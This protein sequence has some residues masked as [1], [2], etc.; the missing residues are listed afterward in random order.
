MCIEN[1][2]RLC[3]FL[4]NVLDCRASHFFRTHFWKPVQEQCLSNWSIHMHHQ[5]LEDSLNA[6]AW[7]LPLQFLHL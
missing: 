1:L 6:G 3:I 4:S 5:L 7:A 2:L